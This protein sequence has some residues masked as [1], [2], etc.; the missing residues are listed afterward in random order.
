MLRAVLFD[1]D[2]TLIHYSEREFFERYIPGIMGLFTDIMP[3]NV[4]IDK[5]LKGTQSLLRNNGEMS[6]AERFLETFCSDHEN[7]RDE[8]WARFTRF[9]DTEYDQL[10]SMVTVS[11]EVREVFLRLTEKNVKLVIASNPIWPLT[12]QTTRL[13]WAGIGDLR[14]DLITHIENTTY[15]KPRLEYYQEICRIIDET[16]E[17]CLMVGNDPVNDMVVAHIGMKT[18]LVTDADEAATELS[19]SAHGN[20]PVEIPEPDFQ[21]PLSAVVDLVEEL[22]RGDQGKPMGTDRP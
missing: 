10:R 11:P 13:S 22:L 18:Y 20:A 14:F 3:G 16:P 6:N 4:F 5:L 17:A 15:C 12:A 21:G 19:R 2:N 1:L 7:L 8:V 9:Y